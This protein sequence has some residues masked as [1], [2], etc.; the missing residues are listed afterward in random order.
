V[1][2][3]FKASAGGY[4]RE[5][6]IVATFSDLEA[7]LTWVTPDIVEPL[8]DVLK[9][10]LRTH[11][12]SA[13]TAQGRLKEGQQVTLSKL[14]IFK[15]LV[16]SRHASDQLYTTAYSALP[17]NQVY[18]VS[19]VPC[20]PILAEAHFFDVVTNEDKQLLLLLGH[21]E[22]ETQDLLTGLIV[23]N[24]EVQPTTLL[25]PLIEF[26][27]NKG[28]LSQFNQTLSSVSFVT[29][30]S[31]DG[32]AG[33]KR[34]KP[35]EVVDQTSSL[36]ALYFNDEQV[37]GSGIYSSNGKYAT[38]LNM[39]GVRNEFNANTAG[40]RINIYSTRCPSDPTELYTKFSVLLT[41]LNR[42]E[43]VGFKDEWLPGMKVPAV[44]G[45]QQSVLHPSQCRPKSLKPVVDGVLGIVT[46][47]LKPFL[48]KVFKWDTVLDPRLIASRIDIIA[49]TNPSAMKRELKPVLRYVQQIATQPSVHIGEYITQ[50]KLNI[51]SPAW[52]PGA[53]KGLWRPD[54]I[55]A[56]D[57]QEFF[58]H[59]C[60]LPS[61]Y[62][63]S[64]E[65]VLKHFGIAQS[66]NAQQLTEVIS[67]LKSTEPLSDKDLALVVAALS[68]LGSKFKDFVGSGLLV[69][70]VHKMLL[71]VDE[72]ETADGEQPRYAHPQVPRAIV[73]KYSIPKLEDDLTLFQY[74]NGPDSGF[75]D[76]YQ[77]EDF[78]R[79]I[80]NSLKES[81]LWSSFNEFLANAEDCGSASQFA[82]ILD[83]E[84]SRYP[85]KHVF[86]EELKA[87][88][89][90][91]LFAYN[92]GVFSEGDFMALVK[93][94]LGSKSDDL[95]KI[96]RY[97]VGTLTMYLFTDLPSFISGK[98]FVI[99]DPTRQYLPL[100]SNRR[101]RRA[102]W[103]VPLLQMRSHF[104]DHLEPFVGIGGY[105]LGAPV[106]VSM[107]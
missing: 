44:N 11:L 49:S 50:V 8:E 84:G 7:V 88:Q 36:A 32:T 67:S 14:P 48:M 3:D 20:L 57:A 64:F 45:T 103:K 95:G 65:T 76:Y 47:D 9:D 90:R 2:K 58:P 24:L 4:L 31:I 98:Y 85:S 99:F 86:C 63:P 16:P 53:E 42:N 107:C 25:D 40:D 60:E 79:R 89:T 34:L 12:L 33:E 43:S 30:C 39:L 18:L 66:P 106:L 77:E 92:D 26:L 10:R 70:D 51:S 62:W 101:Q 78:V 72:F 15:E 82:W 1:H 37:F 38:L 104:S 6:R 94:G 96:G 23:P 91:S 73:Y 35:C 29:V 93:V 71:G 74:L 41:M 68:R 59:M 105:R 83:R 81:S 87:W 61:S 75:E 54:R 52:L 80:S 100:D 46:V 28:T 27:F 102:G 13:I 17:S 19:N 97:G 55:F 5:F 22:L 69:P 21:Q 56:E